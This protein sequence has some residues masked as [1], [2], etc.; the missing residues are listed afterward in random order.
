MSHHSSTPALTSQVLCGIMK[1]CWSRL[2]G[3]VVGWDTY[4]LFKQGEIGEQFSG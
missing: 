4:E 3:G 1:W 2:S